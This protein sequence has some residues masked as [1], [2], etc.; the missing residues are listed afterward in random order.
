MVDMSN[1]TKIAN[2]FRHKF[3]LGKYTRFYSQPYLS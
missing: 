3:K 2:M 1:N